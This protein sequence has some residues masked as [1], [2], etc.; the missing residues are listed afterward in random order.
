MDLVDWK[1]ASVATLHSHRNRAHFHVVLI[2]TNRVAFRD[3]CFRQIPTS[4]HSIRGAGVY[5]L[6]G[7]GE[8]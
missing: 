7:F 8:K 2:E 1:R 5:Q 3:S 4:H 6:S